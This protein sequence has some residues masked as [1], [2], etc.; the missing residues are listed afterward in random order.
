M[1]SCYCCIYCFG[2]SVC[3][4]KNSER[5]TVKGQYGMVMFFNVARDCHYLTLKVPKQLMTELT[6]AELKKKILIIKKGSI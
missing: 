2:Y 3:F 1:L 5:K 6:S 4:V